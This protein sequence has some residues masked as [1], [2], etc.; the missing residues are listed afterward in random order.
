MIT[1]LSSGLFSYAKSSSRTNQDSILA[2]QCIDNGYLIAVADGVGSYLGAEHA[3]QTAIKYLAN[4][5]NASSIQDL[6]SLFAT[7]K[8]KISA[9]SDADESYLE[10]AT[11]LT[12]AYVNNQ[13]LYIGHVGDCRLYIKKDN[14]LKQLTKDHTQHQKLLD[15]KIFNK[16]ELKDMGGKNTLT[17]AI[18][19]VIPLEFQQTFI[20]ASEVFEDNEEATLYILS[21][22]AHHFWDKRPRFSITTLS[23]PN[24]F[25]A[26]LHKRIIRNGPIDDFSLVVAKFKRSSVN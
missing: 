15:Q 16:K 26:S 7:I 10:A 21:D 1:L 20:P 24:C 6:D 22:G 4:L 12:F 11:T 19:K 13:G 17:T 25:A 5:I 3:S 2:P 14:K 18:S 23:N 9:L 8:E